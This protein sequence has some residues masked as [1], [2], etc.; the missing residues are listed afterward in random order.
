MRKSD[1]SIRSIALASINRSLMP[2]VDCRYSKTF[3]SET[4][5]DIFLGDKT[6]DLELPIACT[7]LDNNNYTLVTTRRVITC[8]SGINHTILLQNIKS[9]TPGD[10]K[11]LRGMPTTLGSI[12][13]TDDVVIPVFIETGK[14]SMIMV[15]AIR[16]VMNL[17]E[18]ASS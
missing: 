6:I 3:E 7:F 13:D 16:T 17:V 15:Y 18:K 14:A 11:G 1:K 4:M 5:S 9:F 8:N 10:F 12:I 2:S